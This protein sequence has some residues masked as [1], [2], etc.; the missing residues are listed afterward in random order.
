MKVTLITGASGGIGEAFARA[1][2]AEKHN[3]VLVARSEKK[4]FKLCDEL[5]AK[6]QI[7]AHYIVQDLNEPDAD[8][9]L[10]AETSKHNFEVDFLIN[11]AGFGA[12]GDFVEIDL[13]KQL[14][15]VGLNVMALVALTHRYLP[16]MRQRKSGS[17]INVSSTASFQP[18]PY[19]SVYSA[20]KAFVTSFSEGIA[21]E[22]RRFGI[23]IIACC[24]GATETNFFDAAGI[25]EPFKVKG[26]QKPEEVVEVTLKALKKG[27]THVIS[28]LANWIVAHAATFAPNSLVTRA[29]G[30]QLRPRLSK[31]LK[32]KD[33]K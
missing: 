16:A 7:M 9:K 3:L 4:L 15:M 26:V 29:V 33:E 5:M 13:E 8:A 22:N 12:M 6:H 32:P 20:T 28:G 31:M 24:P 14:E 2:A 30:S 21:E 1:L 25:I 23:K 10:F 11:N 18:L 17:I 27:K 19:F